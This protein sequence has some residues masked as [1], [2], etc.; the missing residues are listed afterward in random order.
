MKQIRR[1]I[2]R[3]LGGMLMLVLLVACSK[4]SSEGGDEPVPEP[5]PTKPVLKLYIF[6]P[7]HPVVTR[8][9]S[10]EV[11]ASGEENKIHTLHIWVFENHQAAGDAH[12]EYDGKLVGYVNMTNV[13]LSQSGSEVAIDIDDN[14]IANKPTVDVF[15]AANVSASNCGITLGEKTA[16]SDLEGMLIN[17]GYFGL[18]SL[19][20]AIPSDG[21]PMSG[22]LKNQPVNG[23]SPVLRVGETGLANVKLVRAVSKVRFVFCKSAA[24][25]ESNLLTIDEIK[26]GYEQTGETPINIKLPKQE[27]LFL[28]GA[29]PDE[30]SNVKTDGEIPYEDVTLIKSSIN[31]D[32]IRKSA[33]PSFYTYTTSMTGQQYEKLINDS[34]KA[35]YLSDVGS[36]YLRESN[37]G[38]AGTIKYKIGSTEK[39]KVFA[40]KDADEFTRNHMWIVYGYF[41]TS[42]ELE[43]NAV[44]VINWNNEDSSGEIYNW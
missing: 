13:A 25:T 26:L 28:N 38:L 14:F 39:T 21:L 32:T 37:N 33:S 4:S 1:Y 31:G 11:D 44:E 17:S 2:E 29:Y 22:V 41:V 7:D 42:G 34:I 24:N 16:R 9:E 19:V 10:Y 23:E 36:Y 43:L 40:T 12:P 35:G 18:T 8:G 30:K 6:A 15:V 20:G 5:E 3:W 27:Y